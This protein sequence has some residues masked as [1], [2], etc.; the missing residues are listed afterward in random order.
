MT[1]I[2]RPASTVVLMDDHSRVYL[3]KR[4]DTM[5]FFGGYY[6][7]PGG[8]VDEDDYILGNKY[9][10]I[11]QKTF[12]IAYL[13]AAARELFEEVGVILCKEK[14]PVVFQYSTESE[15]RQKLINREISFLQILTQ[16]KLSLNLEVL[17]DFGHL[18]TPKD[19]PIR[20]DTRFFLTR[21]PNG[22]KPKPDCYEIEEAAWM[23]PQEALEAYRNE[24]ILLGPPTIL[25]LQTIKNYLDGDSLIMPELK[26]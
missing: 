23:S 13:V 10:S 2:P 1:A 22:Q 21:L 6:V 3:T 5:K 24:Q 20:F 11:I 7:F 8:S 19:K 4:P 16:E 25:A 9:N 18:V 15:Y 17:K 14:S 26:L 12:D